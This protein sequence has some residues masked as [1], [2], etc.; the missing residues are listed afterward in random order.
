MKEKTKQKISN[1]EERL[2]QM[3]EKYKDLQKKYGDVPSKDQKFQLKKY[4]KDM[5][6]L[7]KRI[8]SDQNYVRK[9]ENADAML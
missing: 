7:K 3:E 1:E 6:V 8:Q 9:I 2:G 5:E 4:E